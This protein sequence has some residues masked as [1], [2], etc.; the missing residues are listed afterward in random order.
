M[1][2]QFARAGLSWG[3]ELA[4][5]VLTVC[6][7]FF[8]VL[9][10][11]AAQGMF[12]A[13][14]GSPALYKLLA[15]LFPLWALYVGYRQSGEEGFAARLRIV[16]F[17]AVFTGIQEWIHY[18]NVDLGSYFPGVPNLEW[19]YRLHHGVVNLASEAAPHSYRFLPNGFVLCLEALTRDFFFAKTIYRV[20]FDYLLLLAIYRYAQ[21]FVS[22][23][24]ALVAVL[25]YLVVFTV[26]ITSY[27]GQLTDPL[28]HL[29]FVLAMLSISYERFWFFASTLVFGL[30]AKESVLIMGLC[31]LV[32]VPHR[33]MYAMIRL[34]LLGAVCFG[35][36]V[37]VRA[38]V[39]GP[40][41]GYG[42]IS[43]IT[44]ADILINLKSNWFWQWFF[45][46]GILLVPAALA[47]RR[48]QGELK[49]MLLVLLPGL[50]VAHLLLSWLVETR[51]FIP[52][53]IVLV[54]FAAQYFCDAGS[55]GETAA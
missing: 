41:F 32:C 53:S 35:L 24:A 43:G 45:S 28:S 29:S 31:W 34:V 11:A 46:C 13:A 55:A 48:A 27:A 49:R 38:A 25:S 17:L 9:F 19:Q 54:I 51:N 2:K 36:V 23:P 1:E 14:P 20:S 12:R 44:P 7:G 5:A 22:S 26:S 15:L 18:L 42:N 3:P 4:L 16:L 21:R 8:P 39:A 37:W 33:N 30:F 40:G 47:W 52:C 10:P 50:F 6:M